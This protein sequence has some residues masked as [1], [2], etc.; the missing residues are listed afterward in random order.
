MG[1]LWHFITAGTWGGF[2]DNVTKSPSNLGENPFRRGREKYKMYTCVFFKIFCTT[3]HVELVSDDLTLFYPKI[4][5]TSK[6]DQS[7][8]VVKIDVY[9]TIRPFKITPGT[10]ID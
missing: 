5:E 8:R 6:L 7:T 3:I 10:K 1:T 9:Y 2:T 4:I